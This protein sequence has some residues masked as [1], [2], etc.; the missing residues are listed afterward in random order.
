MSKIVSQ[1]GTLP[2]LIADLE[3]SLCTAEIIGAT[4]LSTDMLTEIV[5]RHKRG[6]YEVYGPW[7]DGRQRKEFW[8][9]DFRDQVEK[10]EDWT[11]EGTREECQA[12]ID[13]QV[14]IAQRFGDDP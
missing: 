14:S 12:W 13:K 3:E 2:G 8:T 7:T 5:Q 4:A 10:G 1:L 6:M 11:F 9:V